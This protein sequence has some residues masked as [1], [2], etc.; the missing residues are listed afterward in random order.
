MMGVLNEMGRTVIAGATATGAVH[1]VMALGRHVDATALHFPRALGS[2]IFEAS[3]ARRLLGWP[4]FVGNGILL[5][6]AY[7]LL[8]PREHATTSA[9]AA[10]GLLHGAA[11]AAGARAFGRLH[12][13]P[14]VAGLPAH[15]RPSAV[16]LA[17]LAGVHVLYG[18]LL[19]VFFSPRSTATRR[20]RSMP[21]S[22]RVLSGLAM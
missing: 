2:V 22:K 8:I 7:R 6:A 9:F 1:A 12:P 15:G 20:S 19:G 5:A 4:L 17:L 18:T 13:R 16:E 11:A 10:L 3:D 14:A 21:S